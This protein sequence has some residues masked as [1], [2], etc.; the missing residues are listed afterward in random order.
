M[1]KQNRRGRNSRGNGKSS[2]KQ[3]KKTTTPK[4]EFVL[5][6][7]RQP[8]VNFQKVVEDVV[9]QLQKMTGMRD[10]VEAIKSGTE[11]DPTRDA[12]YPQLQVSKKADEDAKKVE[13]AVFA[14]VYKEERR[15]WQTR[16]MEYGQKKA[17]AYGYLW[18]RAS[19]A[20]KS[21]V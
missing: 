17:Q 20:M 13:N 9:E 18:A 12:D 1:A 21:M 10:V 16:V 5:A 2:K 6:E 3:T 15:A 11:W 14:E 7:A 8:A 4:L 19:K